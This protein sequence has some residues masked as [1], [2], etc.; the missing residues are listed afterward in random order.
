MERDHDDTKCW[1]WKHLW[2]ILGPLKMLITLWLVLNNKL[3]TWEVLL[4]RG[5]QGPGIFLL[6]KAYTETTSHLFYSCAYA[7][8]L[9]CNTI[10]ILDSASIVDSDSSLELKFRNWWNNER[11]HSHASLPA[12]YVYKIWEATNKAVFSNIWM[13][14]K[15]TCKLLLQKLMEH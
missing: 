7:S 11:V 4:K 2:K 8:T 1:W 12:L 13:P 3:L 10:S 9:W 14:T 15:I 5:L 6:W